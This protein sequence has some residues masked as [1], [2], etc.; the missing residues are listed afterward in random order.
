MKMKLTLSTGILICLCLSSCITSSVVATAAGVKALGEAGSAVTKNVTSLFSGNQAPAN[1]AGKIVSIAGSV[2]NADGST[3]Q[4]NDAF[5]FAENN[6]ATRNIGGQNQSLTYTPK[7]K[8]SAIITISSANGMQETYT[9]T[10]HS[11]DAGSY[12]YEQTCQNAGV[13]TGEGTFNIK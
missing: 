10:F 7:E 9:L 1:I 11:T 2:K 4:M 12:T 8:N 6:T 13:A 3:L 5:S